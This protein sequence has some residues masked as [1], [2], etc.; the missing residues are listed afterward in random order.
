V[1]IFRRNIFHEQ[2]FRTE[3]VRLSSSEDI[4]AARAVQIRAVSMR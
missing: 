1:E 3:V 4:T 2:V